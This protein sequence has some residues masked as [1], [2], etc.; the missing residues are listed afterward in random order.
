MFTFSVASYSLRAFVK[1]RDK[2]PGIKPGRPNIW[3]SV[4]LFS[5]CLVAATICLGKYVYP[6]VYASLGGG[7]PLK[8][9][10]ILT[11]EGVLTWKQFP[12]TVDYDAL[13]KQA[14]ATA[15][16]IPPP[17]S[18]PMVTAEVEI[19]YENEQQIVIK[20]KSQAPGSIVTLD[21]K[22]VSAVIPTE[23]EL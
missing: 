16:S 23:R 10:L 8:A 21:K 2:R 14:G 22:L 17:E 4:V 12:S 18:G 19:L 15:A 1:S 7:R 11:H 5:F 13:A 3:G 9:K 6:K 20:W